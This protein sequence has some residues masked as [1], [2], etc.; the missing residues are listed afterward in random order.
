[1]H[2]N[3][4]IV[5]QV[6]F[7]KK[8]WKALQYFVFQLHCR[9][10]CPSSFHQKKKDITAHRVS[11]AC[12]HNTAD[13]CWSPP[14]W[15]VKNP[16]AAAAPNTPA[17]E[18][19]WCSFSGSPRSA[20]RSAGLGPPPAWSSPPPPPRWC[21]TARSG[22]GARAARPCRRKPWP[23]TGG[24]LPSPAA[25]DGRGACPRWLPCLDGGRDGRGGRGARNLR[26]LIPFVEIGSTALLPPLVG[27]ED[28]K[29]GEGKDC[30]SK[31]TGRN[32]E[33]ELFRI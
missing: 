3:S 28:H 23:E 27:R 24:T 32:N 16:S 26:R 6:P 4:N 19:I 30:R 17:E 12:I 20:G 31:K 8:F 15:C 9:T 10:R 18:L 2:S 14:G 29:K 25:A 33:W 13:I 7:K 5:F 22:G 1:M 21:R 11:A